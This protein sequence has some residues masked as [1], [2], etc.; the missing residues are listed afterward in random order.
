MF[1]FVHE[2]KK[3]VQ[4]VL[5]LILLPFALWGV[6]SYRKS[7]GGEA[8]AT[9][10]GEKISPQE[11]DNALRREQARMR[12]EQGDK[13]DQA[14]FDTPGVKQAIMEGL[15]SQRLLASKA[16][17]A[18][19]S[20]GDEQLAQII[21]GIG[22]FQKDG[23]FDKEL[24]AEVLRAK[25]MTPPQFETLVRQDVATHQLTDAYSQNGYASNTVL[26]NLIRLSEQQR[27]VSLTQVAPDLFLK[28]AKVGDAAVKDYYEENTQE[29]QA[30]EQAKAEFVI[31]SAEAL[32]QQV[33]VDDAEIKQYYDEHQSE[34]GAPEQRQA[35]HILIAVKA[36]AP[37]ADKQAARAKA[38]QI[39]QQVRQQPGK[40]AELAKQ[41][42]QDPGSA[43]NGGDLGFFGHG[44]MVKP[45]DD[46]VFQLKPGEISGL[47][48]TEYGFH[49]IKLLALRA[50]TVQPLNDARASIAAK[51]KQQKAGDKFAELAEKFGNAV[52][53]QSD[54]LKTAAEL[55]KAPVEQSGWLVRG[56]ATPPWTDNALQA[57]FAKEVV[58]DKR[59]SAVVELAPNVLLAARVLEYKPA[60]V[61]PLAEVGEAIR[62]KLQRDQA[63]QLAYKQG[64]VVLEQLKR[65]EQPSL[66]WQT[67]Q[68]MT[69][70]QIVQDNDLAKL[71]KLVFL[72]DVSK[73][74][75]YVG[76]ENEHSGY[77][78]A[79]VD[80]QKEAP[81]LDATQRARFMQQLKKLSGDEM[82]QAYLADA[83]KHAEISIKPLAP[84]EKK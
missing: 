73:L 61:R 81:A 13:F 21:A 48:Q 51:L 12:E 53:E 23:K 27:I 65:G 70:A 43:A 31:L 26:D 79:R 74:P 66:K 36:Q 59:N 3:W 60:S 19:L 62:Q 10:N 6:D 29:F 42:S 30:P 22:P 50:A 69:R 56:H 41:Y 47:V 25:N 24:Y 45:F 9:V 68:V 58:K 34:F 32:Q 39:L 57:L 20:V 38:E 16:R 77:V 63:L 11:F 5:A 54:T 2:N 15:V 37:E 35:A 83:K 14:M 44:M 76:I 1:D 46:A 55:I 17:E 52:Y 49:I 28:D 67:G 7:G 84:D 33:T 18:G 71:A 4:F 82:L 40:F 72:A 64:K 78:L 75:A 8:L 80:E